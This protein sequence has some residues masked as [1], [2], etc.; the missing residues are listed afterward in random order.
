M[1]LKEF[2]LD[3][4]ISG[5]TVVTRNGITVQQLRYYSKNENKCKLIG[6]VAGLLKTWYE[7]GSQSDL[8]DEFDLFVLDEKYYYNI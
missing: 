8:G 3:D 2:N 6:I 5:S 7:D 1:K 4:Y